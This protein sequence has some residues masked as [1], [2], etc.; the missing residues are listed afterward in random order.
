M[1]DMQ[2]TEWGI[3]HNEQGHR[4]NSYLYCHETICPECGY[5]VPLAPSWI[6]GKGTKTVALL[7]ENK[8]MGFDIDIVSNASNEQIKKPKV[9]LQL[10]TAI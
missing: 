2:I 4:A 3:E 5:K 6:I 8:K 9:W 10:K 7:K 1:A